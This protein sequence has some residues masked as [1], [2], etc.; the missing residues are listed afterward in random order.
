[1]STMTETSTTTPVS[2]R[3]KVGLVLAGILS[4]VNVASVF[5]PPPEGEVGPP[6]VVLWVGAAL[7][8]AGLV[9]VVIAWRTGS[10]G[11][12]RVAAVALIISALTAVPA[13]FVDVDAVIKVL[14]AV[15]ALLTVASV[16]L[17][18]SSSRGP[19]PVTD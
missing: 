14:V 16:V 8:V 11:A 17:M 10:R 19:A 7:G 6:M 5:T 9:A 3:Q 2:A 1:M 18:F 4:V 15:A 12:L 13:F